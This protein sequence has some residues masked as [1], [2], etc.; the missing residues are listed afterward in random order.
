MWWIVGAFV[1]FCLV[2]MKVCNDWEKRNA[3]FWKEWDK[4]WPVG[5]EVEYMGVKMKI[6]RNWVDCFDYSM[7]VIDVEY[8]DS[9]GVIQQKRLDEVQLSGTFN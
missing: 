1:A 9:N 2:A 4:K 8:L 7:P 6:V 5:K 3:V